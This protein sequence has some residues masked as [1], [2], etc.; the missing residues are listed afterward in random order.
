MVFHI[1]LDPV[2]WVVYLWFL[3][4]L[5]SRLLAESLIIKGCDSWSDMAL[6]S[7]PV[8]SLGLLHPWC[9]VRTWLIQSCQHRWIM[10]SLRPKWWQILRFD[11]VFL[12]DQLHVLFV[13]GEMLWV[14]TCTRHYY[15]Q[16]ILILK[17][18]QN[19]LVCVWG[20]LD[21]ILP[22][23]FRWFWISCGCLMSGTWSE[24]F[25]S[26]G[27]GE[28]GSLGK[29]HSKWIDEI[30]LEW[31]FFLPIHQ[32]GCSVALRWNFNYSLTSH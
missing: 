29:T 20:S 14:N 12:L 31:K 26:G 6:F 28:S 25:Y 30:K 27:L 1:D 3:Q 16:M 32:P 11:H 18:P 21:K 17:L 24:T 10:T 23:I 8:V 2:L 7:L 9:Y 19:M 13:K 22:P 15:T 4:S 5:T